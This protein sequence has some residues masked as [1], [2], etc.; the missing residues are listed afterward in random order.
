MIELATSGLGTFST[1]SHLKWQ[2]LTSEESRIV[3][4]RSYEEI[5]S[6]N[7]DAQRQL[8]QHGDAAER[9]WAAWAMGVTLGRASTPE[10]LISLRESPAAGTRRH[11]LDRRMTANHP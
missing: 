3:P 6:L 1:S 5:A 7:A 2:R 11:L 8:L 9:V 4:H 10:L